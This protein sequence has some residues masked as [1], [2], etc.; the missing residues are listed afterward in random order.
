[1]V[2]FL[3]L[4]VRPS[5]VKYVMVEWPTNPRH[6]TS[7]GRTQHDHPFSMHSA[8]KFSYLSFFRSKASSMFSSQGTVSSTR[9]TRL[10]LSDHTTISG[11][12]R[13]WTMWDGNWSASLR[14]AADFQSDAPWRSLW[15][16]PLRDGVEGVLPFLQKRMLF[17][18]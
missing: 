11:R 14:S 9:R 6:P 5:L 13:V 1:M 8:R 16:C 2:A 7:M 3:V 15:P 12:S 4:L 17:L 10:V 18:F